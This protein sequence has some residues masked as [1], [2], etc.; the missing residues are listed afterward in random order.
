QLASSNVLR[1]Q[2]DRRRIA[3]PKGVITAGLCCRS[4]RGVAF[5]SS[6]ELF[7]TQCCGV[8]TINRFTF[9]SAGNATPNGVIS[10]NGL[11]NPQDLAFSRSG[12]LFVANANANSISRFRFDAT[13]NATPN[14]LI[15]GTSLHGP[16]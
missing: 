4:P 14:G 2:F 15:T 3:S 6:G 5:S 9:D 11:A 10:G 12:E 8:N 1:L 13:G 16:S 7:V